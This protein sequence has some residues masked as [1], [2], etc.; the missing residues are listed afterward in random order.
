MPNPRSALLALAA[1]TRVR[2]SF[3]REL[4]P[5]PSLRD[6]TG[7]AV[8]RSYQSKH[9]RGVTRAAHSWY[10]QMRSALFGFLQFFF[11]FLLDLEC[12][13]RNN[14]LSFRSSI[15]PHKNAEYPFYVSQ[16]RERFSRVCP[17]T[18]QNPH[19]W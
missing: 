18:S 5:L 9:V 12:Q 7:F 1:S 2:S 4:F 19:R 11:F 16:L 8:C 10:D 6:R 14:D 17:F 3:S 15:W 13:Q